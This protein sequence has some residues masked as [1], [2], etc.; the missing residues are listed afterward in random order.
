MVEEQVAKAKW[1]RY[2]GGNITTAASKAVPVHAI[3][4]YRG[5]GG[6]DPLICN[7]GNKR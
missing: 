6:T 3:K 7:V 1:H 2:E 5:S 4:V